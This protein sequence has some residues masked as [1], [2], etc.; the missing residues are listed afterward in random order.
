MNIARTRYCH[1]SSYFDDFS[2]I[3]YMENRQAEN[4]AITAASAAPFI[5]RCGNGPIPKIKRGSRIA[6]T[7]EEI[8]TTYIDKRGRPSTRSRVL[9]IMEKKRKGA[10][11]TIIM[12]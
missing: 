2:C 9:E 7:I 6:L 11:N 5:P 12:R 4:W 8:R 3:K 1:L 10:L